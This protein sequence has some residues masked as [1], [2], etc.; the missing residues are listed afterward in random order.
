MDIMTTMHK[1]V[2]R[3]IKQSQALL[4]YCDD[5]IALAKTRQSGVTLGRMAIERRSEE[6]RLAR[7]QSVLAAETAQA[8]RELLDPPGWDD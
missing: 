2:N 3:Q 8:Q 5:V 1:K 7:L 4:T 6:K